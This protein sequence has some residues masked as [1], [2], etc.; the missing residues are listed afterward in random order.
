MNSLTIK[1]YDTTPFYNHRYN[2]YSYSYSRTK[3]EYNKDYYQR[4]KEKI[5]RQIKNKQK[6]KITQKNY[7]ENNKEILINKMKEYYQKNKDKLK[8]YAKEY[9]QKRKNS[10]I[11]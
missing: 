11:P 9:Y 7:Y 10:I 8:E 3:T 2:S 1:T 4:N 6:D 5:L